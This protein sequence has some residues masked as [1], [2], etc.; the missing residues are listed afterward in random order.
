MPVRKGHEADEHLRTGLLTP[1]FEPRPRLP[2]QW[3]VAL[4]GLLPDTVALPSPVLTGFP[5]IGRYPSI[6]RG[7]SLP[8]VKERDQP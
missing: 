7:L 6:G 3:P 4:G 2:S 5:Y 8:A 1:G